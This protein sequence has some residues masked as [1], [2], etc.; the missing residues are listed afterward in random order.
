LPKREIVSWQAS[1]LSDA[2]HGAHKQKIL[3]RIARKLLAKRITLR[4]RLMT[5]EDVPEAMRLKGAAGW[6]QTRADWARFLSSTPEGCFVAE[7]RGRVVG[8]A[9]SIV[10]EG[11]FAWIGMVTV[12]PQYRG[13][14]IGTALLQ[15]VIRY[16]D[17]RRVPCMK[18]DATPQGKPVYEKLG[19]VSEY[20]IER[21]ML[22]QRQGLNVA[23]NSPTGIERR[24]A[25][26]SGNLRS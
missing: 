15:S 3:L 11:R 6:N 22:K 14:G 26:S 7:D 16:L 18:L 12:D 25:G 17:S 20:G 23:R 8:T 24:A 5:V 1:N 9:T 19:F 10:Y 13:Q 21:W 2:V 4:F